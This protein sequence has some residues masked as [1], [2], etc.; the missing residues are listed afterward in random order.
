MGKYDYTQV[1]SDY[2]TPQILI[3]K[4]FDILNDL[5]FEKTIFD[6]DVC[7]TK[8][9][10]PAIHHYTNDCHNGLNE[11]WFDLNFCNPPFKECNKWIK[12]AY[13]EMLNGKSTVLLIPARTETKYWQE[14]ILNNEQANKKDVHVYF[15][16]KGYSFLNAQTNEPMGIFKNALAIVVFD[17]RMHANNK[18]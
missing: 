14:Y 16:R 10:I 9:N 5:S 12:K 1:A 7:C 4:C 17:G 6:L 13:I 8:K 11:N 18:R 15:L 2:L 3:D